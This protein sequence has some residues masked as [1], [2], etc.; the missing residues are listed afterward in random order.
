MKMSKI[1]KEI[2]ERQKFT[3][4]SSTRF[5]QRQNSH[6]SESSNGDSKSRIQYKSRGEKRSGRLIT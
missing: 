6:S 4:E 2:I 5:N 3:S 1:K